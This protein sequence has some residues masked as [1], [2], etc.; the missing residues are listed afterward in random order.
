MKQ[1]WILLALLMAVS[2]A[3]TAEENNHSSLN[4]GVSITI[5]KARH[6]LWLYRGEKLSKV[7]KVFL[8]SSPE[9]DKD[10][11]GDF[12]TPLGD[13]RVV[14]KKND[15]KFHRFIGINYPNLKDADQA[16]EDG[17]ITAEQWVDIL[18]AAETGTKPPWDTPLGGY[19]GIHGI[20]DDEEFKLRL[21]EDTDWT[22]G[23]VA[24]T[25][26]NVNELYHLL[27]IGTTVR[28]RE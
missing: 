5:F 14:E 21:I 20:G 10:R 19:I 6:E 12:K 26:R 22:N 17:R 7:Y 23:C 28:I 18:Y 9:G 15:S 25:N 16:Y 11:R 4:R 8:G 24:V 3:A 27:P 13:Y 2:A 1:L